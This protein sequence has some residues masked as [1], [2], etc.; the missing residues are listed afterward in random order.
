MNDVRFSSAVHML[1]LASEADVPMSS[2]QIAVSIGTNP[3]WIRKLASS[4]RAAG[5]ITSHPGQTG[6]ALAVPAD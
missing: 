4:L 3:S 5:L 2:S 6:F 1:I